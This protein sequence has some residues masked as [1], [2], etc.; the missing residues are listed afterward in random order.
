MRT[1]IPRSIYKKLKMSTYLLA[2][3]TLLLTIPSQLF[4]Q[5]LDV[6]YVPTPE[7]V[8]EQMLDLVDAQPSDY[9]IDLGSGDGR[10]VIAAA[11]RGATGH[12]IDLDPDRIA[13][14]RDNATENGVDDQIMF[15]EGDI[16]KT[17]FSKASIIT[18]Y[19]LPS[20]N[21]KLRPELLDKLE[22]GTQIVSHSFDMGD[23]EPDKQKAVDV[24]GPSGAHDIYYWVI[25]AKVDGNWSW[26]SDGKYF[27]MDIDQEFQKIDVSLSDR[28]GNT[29]TIKKAQLQG[30]RINI[31][32]TS[33]SQNYIFSGRVEDGKIEG[34]VQQHNGENKTLSQWEATIN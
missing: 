22:P 33:G 34:M 12:G 7:N 23:W 26:S 31:R 1:Y 15:I 4:A 28:D 19:L 24:N 20:V 30:R 16:F 14:A 5:D 21:E 2:F 8:V 29:Y 13:E 10:I 27:S 32:A 18:M 25:P 9:V 11:K 6:P 17:D 3:C